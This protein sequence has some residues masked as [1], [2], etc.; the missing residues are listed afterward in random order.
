M[1]EEIVKFYLSLCD[2]D[3]A[4]AKTCQKFGI[5]EDTLYFILEA[6]LV[7]SFMN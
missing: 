5:D 7:E 2:D 1:E 4:E 3:D 6:D